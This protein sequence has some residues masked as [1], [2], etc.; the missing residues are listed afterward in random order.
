M[1]WLPGSEAMF[2]GGAVLVVPAVLARSLVGATWLQVGCGFVVWFL[3][4]WLL[5]GGAS[6]SRGEGLGWTIIMGMFFSW[7]GVP[8][9]TLAM[10]LTNVPYRFM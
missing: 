10:R 2:V 3:C 6:L 1:N 9:T 8:L 4:L 5:L 7:L